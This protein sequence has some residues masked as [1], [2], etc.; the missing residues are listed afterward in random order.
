M[1]F[2]FGYRYPRYVRFGVVLMGMISSIDAGKKRAWIGP[3]MFISGAP[4]SRQA[5]GFA[6]AGGKLYIF[7]GQGTTGEKSLVEQSIRN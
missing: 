5:H 3:S 6:T 4:S 2:R 7:G 1:G